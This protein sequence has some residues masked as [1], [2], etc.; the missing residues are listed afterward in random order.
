MEGGFLAPSI[1]I[2]QV[3]DEF[4]CL[5]IVRETVQQGLR[6]ALSNNC[7]FGGTNATLILKRWDANAHTSN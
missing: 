1:N 4:T 7:G 5:P 6:V 3:D 2:D